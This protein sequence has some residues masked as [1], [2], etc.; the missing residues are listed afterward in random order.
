MKKRGE[1][2]LELPMKTGYLFDTKENFNQNYAQKFDYLHPSIISAL[3]QK[4]IPKLKALNKPL[5]IWTFKTNK[6]AEKINQIYQ[7]Q[8]NGYISDLANL[9]WKKEKSH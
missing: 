3:N 7:A 6:Q 1:R 5:N 8:V 9:K 4:M 2:K